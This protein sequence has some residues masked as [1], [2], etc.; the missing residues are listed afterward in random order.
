MAINKALGNL[1]IGVCIVIAAVAAKYSFWPIVV[2][3]GL[4]AIWQMIPEKGE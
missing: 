1:N 3:Y 2:L 4:L